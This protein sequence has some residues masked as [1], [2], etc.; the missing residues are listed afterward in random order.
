MPGPEEA[1][2]RERVIS[3]KKRI[4]ALQLEVDQ[5][6]RKL[7]HA[8]QRRASSSPDASPDD[9]GDGSYKRRSKT[10]PSESFSYEKDNHHKRRHMSP[11]RKGVRNDAIGKALD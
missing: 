11:P 3:L 2:H 10:P 4:P 9:K 8:Q 7:R 6:K 5:L 1:S